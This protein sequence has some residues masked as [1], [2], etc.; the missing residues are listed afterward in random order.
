[1]F[2]KRIQAMR[3]V[4]I[5]LLLIISMNPVFSQGSAGEDARYESR[6]VVDMPTSGLL[7]KGSFSMYAMIYA[8]GGMLAEISAAPFDNFNMGISFSGS[9]IIG[10]GNVTWQEIP[11]VHLRYRFF[12]ETTVTPAV[13]IG[14]NTQGRGEYDRELNR[15]RTLSPGLFVAA[16]KSFGW[17]LGDIALHGGLNYSFEPPSDKRAVNLWLGIEHSIGKPASIS[18]EYNANI[19]EKGREFMSSRGLFNAAIRLNVSSGLTMELQ[20]RDILEH[21]ANISGFT[22]YIGFEFISAF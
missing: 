2:R 18:L 11:G 21:Q 3:L 12:D 5:I 10:S 20:I 15:F 19:D 17:L 22:R 13:C 14:V 1:M 6:Y 8:G 9:N 16:S 7:T 4:S